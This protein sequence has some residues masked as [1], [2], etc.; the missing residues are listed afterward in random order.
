[1]QPTPEKSVRPG[2]TP[3]PELAIGL[4]ADDAAR[5]TCF[6]VEIDKLACRIGGWP[7]DAVV[8]ALDVLN[9]SQVLLKGG[10][11]D[12]LRKDGGPRFPKAG[13]EFSA[14]ASNEQYREAVA[15]ASVEA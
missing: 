6:G 14:V 12:G 8:Y 5:P 4:P 7:V 10:V 3:Q 1:M 2:T 11:P 15:L 9:P 13:P